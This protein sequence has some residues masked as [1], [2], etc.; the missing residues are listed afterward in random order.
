MTQWRRPPEGSDAAAGLETRPQ[1][2]WP[3]VVSRA[4][5]LLKG[6]GSGRARDEEQQKMA[7]LAP[8]LTEGGVRPP[9]TKREG[10]G[11]CGEADTGKGQERCFPQVFQFLSSSFPN[12]QSSVCN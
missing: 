5:A 11:L 2:P 9:A 8:H 7:A 1:G 6:R 10:K 12:Q 3:W 4:G